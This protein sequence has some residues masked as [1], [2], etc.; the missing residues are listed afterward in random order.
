MGDRSNGTIRI[1][2]TEETRLFYEE[3]GWR[4]ECGKPVDLDLFGIKENGPIRIEL[5][6]VQIFLA[7]APTGTTHNSDSLYPVMDICYA[8]GFLCGES[9]RARRN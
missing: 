9:H 2:G 7:S 8:V 5:N 6:R 4:V 3:V 1:A